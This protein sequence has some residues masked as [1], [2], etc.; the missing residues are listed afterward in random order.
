MS[1][2]DYKHCLICNRAARTPCRLHICAFSCHNSTLFFVTFQHLLPLL[3]LEHDVIWM[4]M[5][6]NWYFDAH[7]PMRNTIFPNEIEYLSG[8]ARIAI[9]LSPL[10]PKKKTQR[11]SLVS[12]PL[13]VPVLLVCASKKFLSR[14]ATLIG[15]SSRRQTCDILMLCP[16][17]HIHCWPCSLPACLLFDFCLA[18]RG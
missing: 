6:L 5:D 17:S 1:N 9:K 4:R 11:H 13:G 15:S 2:I 7:T 8:N 10:K 16:D 12:Q 14:Q 3:F 18:L